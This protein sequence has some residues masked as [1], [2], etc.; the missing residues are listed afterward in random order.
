MPG[1]AVTISTF[2]TDTHILK[3]FIRHRFLCCA[4]A[5]VVNARQYGDQLYERLKLVLEEHLSDSTARFRNCSNDDLSGFFHELDA[6]W[7]E[8]KTSAARIRDCLRYMV[9][10]GLYCYARLLLRPGARVA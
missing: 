6:M 7:V 8:Y 10:S 1:R 2:R 5:F 4:R 3:S 9:L